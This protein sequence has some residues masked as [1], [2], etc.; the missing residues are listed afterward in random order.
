MGEKG[1]RLS[2]QG[3]KPLEPG[4][5]IV[6][7]EVLETRRRL[8]LKVNELIRLAN[9]PTLTTSDIQQHL[10]PCAEEFGRQLA[11]LL[12]RALHRDDSQERHAI[13]WLLALLNDPASIT[14]LHHMSHNK[15]L[16]RA[17]RLSAAL[18]LA[19]MGATPEMRD[20]QRRARPYAIG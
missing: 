9:N 16:P 6:E 18:A 3:T 1:A 10:R 14:P 2:Q 13:A 20:D 19:G 17:V 5:N 11:A 15:R 12:V 8:R 7:L 4:W